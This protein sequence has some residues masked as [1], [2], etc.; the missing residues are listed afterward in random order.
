MVLSYTRPD[1]GLERLMMIHSYPKPDI[2]LERPKTLL[3]ETRHQIRETNDPLL[4]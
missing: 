1:I 3:H 2:R 4:H